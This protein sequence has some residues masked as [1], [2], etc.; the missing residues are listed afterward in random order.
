MRSCSAPDLSGREVTIIRAI[1]RY[2]RQAGIPYSN[3]Y[4]ERTLVRH[5]DVAALLVRLFEARLDPGAH[6][7]RRAEALAAGDHRGDR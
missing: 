6:D 2:L 3:A 1:A 5:G 7:A 4:M